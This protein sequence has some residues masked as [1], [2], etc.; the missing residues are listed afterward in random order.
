MQLHTPTYLGPRFGVEASENGTYRAA[1]Y[2]ADGS[3]KDMMVER[4][5]YGEAFAAAMRVAGGE[6]DATS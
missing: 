6:G 5:S 3:V 2:H 4:L 1:L